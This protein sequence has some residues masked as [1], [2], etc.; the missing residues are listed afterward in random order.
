MAN[1]FKIVDRIWNVYIHPEK[2]VEYARKLGV[3]I[4]DNCQIL[5]DPVNAF[6]TE[7]WLITIGNHVDITTDVQ[8][9]THEGGIWVA[10]GLNPL[11]E[12]Y[13]KFAPIKIGSN[14]MIG[15]RSIIMPGVTVGDNVIIA[16][17]SIV[18]KDIPSNSI[19]GG[20]PAKQISNIDKFMENM[21]TGV[22]PTKHMTA[23]EKKEWILQNCPELLR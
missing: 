8:F 19:V 22:I 2:R 18:T 16:A 5:C 13:D 3:R 21:K 11:Y 9:L 15:F 10:R 7:P 6:G 12:K 23:G 17:N 4:G 14:V 1:I 20:M